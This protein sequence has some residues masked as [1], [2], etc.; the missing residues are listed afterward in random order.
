MNNNKTEEILWVNTLKGACIL[1]VVLYHVVL[2]GYQ[3]TVQYLTAGIIPARL[4]I[5]FNTVLSPL[6]MPAFFFVSGL[7]AANAIIN[8]PWKEVF[9]SRVTNLFY[10]YILWGVIQWLSIYSISTGITG[11]RISQ[12]LNS[13]YSQ[14][15]LEF[16]KLMLLAMSSSWYLYAL[17]LFFLLAKLFHQQRLPLMAGALLLNYAAVD[18]IIP[19]WGPE[20]LS[21]YFI[22]FLLGAFYSSAMIRLSEWHRSNILPWLLLLALAAVHIWLG[23]DKS[24]F[25][26]VLAIVCCIAITRKLNQ[27]FNLSLLNWMGKNTLQIYVLHRIFIE[28]FGMT[29]ILFALQHQLFSHHLFSLVWAI[30]FPVAMVALCSACSM[31]VWTL[32]NRGM[33]KSLF[34]Y[35][36]LLRMKFNH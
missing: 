13:S 6:R 1:L 29:A 19:G 23:L 22:Y 3:G 14:S 7:L 24:I 35:P 30:G 4:W 25:L 15:P 32:L 31:A 21:Q 34:I 10:L 28:Y 2:P 36:K 27:H 5:E 12:N 26:C 16:I 11:Q 18:N 17:G 33:G 8:K 20:S 9:T